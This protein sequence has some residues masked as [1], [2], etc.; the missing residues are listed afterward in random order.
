MGSIHLLLQGITAVLRSNCPSFLN[1]R[2]KCETS[3]PFPLSC[4]WIILSLE[5]SH[6]FLAENSS[7]MLF[8][9][10]SLPVT[11]LLVSTLL[12]ERPKSLS[13]FHLI[14]PFLSTGG[15]GGH[16]CEHMLTP[17]YLL[18]PCSAW[19]MFAA[20]QKPILKFVL[21]K[22]GDLFCCYTLLI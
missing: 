14:I 8:S 22:S 21:K 13:L 20:S 6:V 18:I 16:M 9:Q 11:T 5:D 4:P 1:C 19:A 15:W 17:T 12:L 7:F 2:G 3:V 10:N